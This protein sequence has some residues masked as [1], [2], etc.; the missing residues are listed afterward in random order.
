[1]D[2]YP[3]KTYGQNMMRRAYTPERCAEAVWTTFG[4]YQC[5]RKPGH[6]DRQLFC[7]QHA[8]KHPEVQP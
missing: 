6:G 1:M 8:K 3:K 5:A 4:S 2:E 7:K